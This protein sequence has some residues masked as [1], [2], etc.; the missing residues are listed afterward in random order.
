MDSE[1]IASYGMI[2]PSPSHMSSDI[3]MNEESNQLL[4]WMYK[5]LNVLGYEE[6]LVSKLP[7]NIDEI[8]DFIS[9]DSPKILL[10]YEDQRNLLLKC[11][12]SELITALPSN[13]RGYFIRS[14]PEIL[15]IHNINNSVQYGTVGSR[16]LTIKSLN[17]IMKGIVERQIVDNKE[18][19][20]HYHR[21]MATLIDAAHAS[22]G[23]TVLYCPTFE[24]ET[25]SKVAHDKD[26]LQIMESIVIHWT[27]QIKDLINIHENSTSSDS[28][29]PIDEIE[30]WRIR[31]H[32]LL[33][34]QDQ[35]QS[36]PVRRI[37]CVLEYVKSNYLVPFQSR[38]NEV[39]AKAIEARDNL[40]FL[41]TIRKQCTDLRELEP[42]KVATILP[43]LLSRLRLIWIHSSYYSVNDNISNLLR[44]VSSEIISRFRAYIPI[45]EI[46]DG[47]I[48]FCIL[49]LNEAIHCVKQWKHY[50]Y[51]TVEATR[52]T[53]EKYNNRVWDID[54]TVIFAQI[55]AFVQRCH[56]LLEICESQIQ[57]CRKS[58]ATK[59]NPG[60]L[61]LFGSTKAQ[62]IIDGIVGIQKSFQDRINRLRSLDYDILDVRISKWHTDYHIFK[63]G[64]KDL[65]VMFTNV[66]NA[67]FD[68]NTSVRDCVILVETFDMLA[69]RDLIRRCID[70]KAFDVMQMFMAQTQRM[71][72]E[73]EE[74]RLSPPLRRLEPQY[75]GSAIWANSL[76]MLIKEGYDCLQKIT[77][78]LSSRDID[79]LNEIYS[80]FVA[81]IDSFKKLRYTQWIEDVQLKANDNGFQRRLE[82]T[83]LRKAHSTNLPI[84][85]NDLNSNTEELASTLNTSIKI[86]V[87]MALYPHKSNPNDLVCNFDEDILL[88]FAEVNY[89]EKFH[90][91]E[92]TVPDIVHDV[93]NKRDNL[94]I[95]QLHVMNLVRAYNQIL[96]D[97]NPEERRLFIDHINRLDRKIKP[98]ISKITWH[99]KNLIDIFV[100][101][102]CLLCEEVH[103]VV[104]DFK[105][106]KNSIS[107][108]CDEISNTI[109]LKVDKN[110]GYKSKSFN[111]TQNEYRNMLIEKFNSQ[112]QT[113]ITN[114]KRSFK[115][116]REGGSE[117]Q[118]EWR[119]QINQ[120][121][122]NIN[123]S[124]FLI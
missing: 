113:I 54:D 82:K 53:K 122:C 79:E 76:S 91:E 29:G 47:D 36:E 8:I 28:N 123:E 93:I 21:L 59:G 52:R 39:I 95:M 104:K 14:S 50:Y 9:N 5:K 81:A 17:L 110:H 90:D 26:R 43:D 66:I 96:H 114:L 62:E 18:L 31:T 24:Y 107:K 77:T 118:R 1:T 116:F 49:R 68:N 121:M 124:Q 112:Y 71:R 83:L 23:I 70:K 100:R 34:I 87:D 27:R 92:F 88:L 13:I 103:G 78:H 6:S 48:E 85:Q 105:E 61:P 86:D 55:D 56:D 106:S 115:C 4:I 44:M 57:F 30:F 25:V 46:M 12:L 69:K 73:F 15:S 108:I 32:N 119:S 120:V 67:A 38:T 42:N 65:E 101:D 40:K 84:S 89:W 3:N 58:K 102:S 60:P 20:W 37:T 109:L 10:I 111:D 7:S 74:H 51:S 2:N 75:S 35:L 22:E 11:S 16:G 64:V 63:N 99:S 97:I 98:G 45:R 80:T 72:R 94:R 19:S 33:G 117:V 41:E